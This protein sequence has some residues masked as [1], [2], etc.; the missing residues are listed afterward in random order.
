MGD[1]PKGELFKMTQAIPSAPSSTRMVVFDFDGTIARTAN[2]R[3]TW[4]M[5]WEHLGYPREECAGYHARYRAG[6]FTHTDWCKFTLEKFRD[7]KLTQSVLTELAGMLKVLDGFAELVEEL[8][9]RRIPLH[10]VS[11]SIDAIIRDVLGT[12]AASFA[13]IQANKLVFSADGVISD[14]IETPYD[15]EGKAD[16]IRLLVSKRNCAPKEVLFVGNADNDH[17]V[18]D[19]GVR[20]LCVNPISTDPEDHKAWTANIRSMQDM[21]QILDYV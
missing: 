12:H 15:F 2:G 10:I 6:E 21:K 4:E 1:V 17:W 11:G 9:R 7:R 18:A 8:G 16:Y 20:T 19:A 3:T 5:I 13:S 14:I